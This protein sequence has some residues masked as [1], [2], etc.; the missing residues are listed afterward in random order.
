MLDRISGDILERM[1]G[2]L[3]KY[4]RRYNRKNGR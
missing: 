4:V 3:R 2:D 1:I